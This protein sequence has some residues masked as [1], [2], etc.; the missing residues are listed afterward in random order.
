MAKLDEYKRADAPLPETYRAWQVFGAGLENVGRGG[1][2]VTVPLR[3]PADDEIV[4]RIDVLGLCL[5][6]MKIIALGS[7]HPRLRGRDLAKDPTVLGHECACTVVK[8]GKNRQ[9]RFHAG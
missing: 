4:V 7:E 6:D 1:E 8:A 9:D 2:P 3:E 5:S